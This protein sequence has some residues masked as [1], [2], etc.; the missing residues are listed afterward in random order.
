MTTDELRKAF[1]DFFV[2]RHDHIIK[3][4]D[5]LVPPPEDKSLLFTGAGMNQFKPEFA[6]R[7]RFPQKRVVTSQKCLRTDDIDHVGRTA[8][9]HSFFEMLGNF[10]FGDYFKKGAMEMAWEFLL[11]VLKLPPAKLQVSCHD[12]DDE[13]YDIWKSDIGLSADI[14]H[15]FG[16]KENFWPAQAPVKGP[17][18]LCGPCAEIFY[19][20]GEEH[21]CGRPECDPSCDCNRFSEVWNLVFQQFDR[22][23]GGVLDPLPSKNIDTGAGLERLAAVMQGDDAGDLFD[24]LVDMPFVQTRPDYWEYHPRVRHLMLDY[25][26]RRSTKDANLVHGRLR[27]YYKQLLS[28]NDQGTRYRDET[29]RQWILEMLYHGLM[30]DDAEAYSQGI[31]AFLLALRRR[32]SFA[33]DVALAWQ[34]AAHEQA[35][36]SEL[37]RWARLI[38]STWEALES[39]SLKAALPFCKAVQSRQ[40]VSATALSQVFFISGIVARDELQNATR[41]LAEFSRAVELDPRSVLALAARGQVRADLGQHQRAVADYDQAIELAPEDADIFISRGNAYLHLKQYRRAIAY[42]DHAIEL[43]PEDTTAYNNR[44]FAYRNL[45]QYERAIADYDRAIELNLENADVYLFRGFTYFR[46]GQYTRAAADYS[47]AI[48]LDPDNITAY[49]SRGL[50]RHRSGQLERAIADFDRAIE[51]NPEDA[52]LNNSRGAVYGELEQ[53]ERSIADFDR[54]IELIPE[55]TTAYNNRGFAYRSLEQYERAIADYDRAIGLD[56]SSAAAFL[57]RGM[58]Y[59]HLEQYEQA[60]ADYDRSIVLDPEDTTAYYFRGVSYHDLGQ[61]Q[62]AIADFDRAIELDSEDG[63]AFRNRGTAYFDL[64]EYE[65][66]IADYDRA[67]ELDPEYGAAYY[68][69]GCAFDE[70]EQYEQA[71]ADFNL[72]IELGPKDAVAYWSRGI[73]YTD[74][75]LYERAIADYDRAIELN[76]EEASIYS[77]RGIAYLNLEQYE[78][79]IADFNLAIELDPDDASAYYNKACAYALLCRADEAG[80]WLEKAITLDVEYRETARADPDFDR[81][82]DH[83]RF[84]T[85]A[86]A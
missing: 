7:P 49:H 53:Y 19:D 17:N 32:Y 11:D 80:G 65:R 8:F 54:A 34:Q 66:A 81:I 38:G 10:S 68:N 30:Q 48:E 23:D 56:P 35:Y 6:G 62:R 44:G 86:T 2:E 22:K 78:Q 77:D 79:A 63:I 1:L 15:R 72:A 51:L 24:W 12:G 70:L 14:I 41:S 57:D 16:D 76:L 31:E 27:A 47:R 85:L 71:I 39:N 29:W 3:P 42:Y 50:A 33:G 58:V 60:I 73:A 64:G 69:R 46:L 13:A 67:I 52:T 45:E 4:S 20:W 74:L 59:I 37:V 84:R 40:D 25:A 83:V 82:R 28:E 55:D 26:R 61:N 5:S 9:H 43:N 75:K 36:L 18:G 21:G